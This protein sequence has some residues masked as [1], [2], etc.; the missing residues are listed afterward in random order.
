[1]LLQVRVVAGRLVA[2]SFF[3]KGEDCAI[4]IPKKG[5]RGGDVG[6]PFFFV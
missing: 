4:S 1:M 5:V 2:L 6:L 3:Q